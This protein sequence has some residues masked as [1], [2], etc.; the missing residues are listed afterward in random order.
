MAEILVTGSTGQLGRPTAAALRAAGH[1]VRGLN[2]SGGDGAVSADLATGRGLEAACRDIATV[3]HLATANGAGDIGMARNLTRAARAAG[4]GHLVLVSIVGIDRIP[5]GFYRDRLRIEELARDSGVP[6]TVQRA[7][8][9]HSLVDRLF[10]AQRMLPVV[11]V[12]RHWRFQPIAVEDVAVRLAALAEGG[13]QGRVDDIGGPAVRSLP[14]LYAA[15]R[16]ATGGR[17]PALGVPIPGRLGAAFAA[18]RNLVPG[19][20]YGTRDFE[21][22]LAEKYR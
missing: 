4:V 13:P 16:G 1:A 5:L 3:V 10:A 20:P 19:A 6:L 17:R 2:R 22:Y 18:G 14:E 11:L 12:P 9:F 7:T 21:S 8:Q 15:W